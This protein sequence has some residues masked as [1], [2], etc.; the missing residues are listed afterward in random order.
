M[1]ETASPVL[2]A[3]KSKPIKDLRRAAPAAESHSSFSSEPLHFLLM[4]PISQY[5]T[6]EGHT[7]IISTELPLRPLRLTA[8]VTELQSAA[9]KWELMRCHRLRL[10]AVMPLWSG[11]SRWHPAGVH[12]PPRT[13]QTLGP[14]T[15]ASLTD[16]RQGAPAGD[17][18]ETACTASTTASLLLELSL[19]ALN[20]G[21]PARLHRHRRGVLVDDAKGP[22]WCCS[23]PFSYTS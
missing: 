11:C 21:R 8:R 13:M 16:G 20:G 4:R 10:R 2:A 9:E 15:C 1:T 23:L 17:F 19:L 5:E 6:L 7:D 14:A 12:A 18:T 22:Y 3:M